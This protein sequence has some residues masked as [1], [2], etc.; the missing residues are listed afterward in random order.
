LIFF[1]WLLAFRAILHKIVF[2][3]YINS[4]RFL[5]KKKNLVKATASVSPIYW[6]VGYRILVGKAESVTKATAVGAPAVE[7]WAASRVEEN[8][9][10][11][12]LQIQAR[13]MLV[14]EI[15]IKKKPEQTHRVVL[16][17]LPLKLNSNQGTIHLP[18]KIPL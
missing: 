13:E 9:R 16:T 3:F 8:S 2:V 1:Q 6:N 15:F 17:R 14:S 7:S 4:L 5:T 10:S 11:E 12:C 18:L